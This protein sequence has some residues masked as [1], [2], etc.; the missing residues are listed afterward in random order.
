MSRYDQTDKKRSNIKDASHNSKQ[1]KYHYGTTIYDDVPKSNDDIYVITQSGDRLDQLAYQFY[2]D[3]HLWWFIARANNISTMNISAG[4][5]LRIPT[6]I[7]NA[8][9]S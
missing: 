9:G 7:V 4:T 8:Q 1:I 5:R 6:S 3:Q 2:G